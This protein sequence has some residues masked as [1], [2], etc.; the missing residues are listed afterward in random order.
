MLPKLTINNHVIERHKSVKFLWVPLDENLSWEE[1]IKYT[2]NK[3]T[4]NLGLIYKARSFSK[5]NALLAL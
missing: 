2:E 4:K 1:D 3:I 5:K